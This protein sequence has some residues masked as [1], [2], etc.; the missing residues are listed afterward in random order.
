MDT[1][2]LHN[3]IYDINTYYASH[4]IY[5]SLIICDSDNDVNILADLMQTE[6]YS[7]YRITENDLTYNLS[8]RSKI[9][10][11]NTTEFRVIVISY[12]VWNIIRIE[13]ETYILP[14]QNLIVFN[15][16]SE[17]CL[18]K[19]YDWVY[20]TMN[21]GFITRPF[22]SILNSKSEGLEH[23]QLVS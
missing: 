21:R 23:I 10:N 3:I 15:L 14:E 5:K 9:T 18:G 4:N 2:A 1:T 11:F 17:D 19:L 12:D 20:D 8:L 16:L 6:L 22:S 7:I 13:L